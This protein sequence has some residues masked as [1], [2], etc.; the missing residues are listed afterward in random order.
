MAAKG[1]TPKYNLKLPFVTMVYLLWY[2]NVAKYKYLGKVKH[3][4]M[5]PAVTPIHICDL[6]GDLI[7]L[8]LASCIV[9]LFVALQLIFVDHSSGW[10]SLCVLLMFW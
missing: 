9:Y 1:L 3:E 2:F 7:S 8:Q 4:P 6:R 10:L 5:R